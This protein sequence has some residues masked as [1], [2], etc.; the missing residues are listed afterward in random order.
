[1]STTSHEATVDKG[2]KAVSNQNKT[3]YPAHCSN[4]C[5]RLS[6]PKKHF[7]HCYHESLTDYD[8]AKLLLLSDHFVVKAFY[9]AE[10]QSKHK[11]LIFCQRQ[12]SNSASVACRLVC[13]LSNEEHNIAEINIYTSQIVK[14]KQKQELITKSL[15]ILPLHI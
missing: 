10:E 13:E 15:E 2:P 14:K 4:S 8:P 6:S 9:V 12:T 5:V 7:T 1:M 11:A 3:V